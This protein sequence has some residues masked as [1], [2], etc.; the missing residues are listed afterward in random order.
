MQAIGGGRRDVRR[1]VTRELVPLAVIGIGAGVVAG[2]SGT[3]AIIG[4][5]EASNAVDIGARL[6]VAAVPVVAVATVAGAAV[7]AA[8]AA[9]RSARRSIAATL[10]GAA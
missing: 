10:R 7:L 2:W 4:S 8:V 9:R 3:V 6:A 1:L 5:F